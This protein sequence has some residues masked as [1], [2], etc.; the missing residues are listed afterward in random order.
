[1]SAARISAGLTAPMPRSRL[2][3]A[4]A[5]GRKVL[6][7]AG[8]GFGKT[9][10]ADQ[11]RESLG[12]GTVTLR[13]APR[14]ADPALLCATLLRSLRASR[15]SDLASAVEGRETLDEA[16]D[17]LLDALAATTSQVLLVIDDAHHVLG[18]SAAA[19]VDRLGSDLPG[20]H[21]LMVVTRAMS[22]AAG[23]AWRTPG[24]VRI[25]VADLAFTCGEVQELLRSCFGA[26]LPDHAV[27]IL[28]H[29][30]GGW[31]AAVVLSAALVAAA[32]D[33]WRRCTALLGER[34]FW[35][36]WST[37]SWLPSAPANAGPWPSCPT[38]RCCPTGWRR[39]SPGSLVCSLRL[40]KLA[41][42][43]PR[44]RPAGAASPTR[45]PST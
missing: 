21:H 42:L 12:I 17:F 20:Q 24:R 35:A 22:A 41:C 43:P 7:E 32:A 9:V 16:L 25:G 11:H 18:T 23:V 3:D 30:T 40:R 33:P 34:L 8:A 29:A 4:V 36:G 27:A 45:L 2:L 26:T 44:G 10:L 13:L 37:T 28:H 39:Q 15:L 38:C 6:V 19:I 5:V 31:P 14:D 1:M